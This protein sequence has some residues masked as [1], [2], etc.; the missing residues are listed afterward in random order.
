MTSILID[1]RRE[2]LDRLEPLGYT[3]C[4]HPE[5]QQSF[6]TMETLPAR[7]FLDVSFVDDTAVLF[8]SDANE[9][10]PQLVIHLV[11]AM[12]TAVGRRGLH[13]SLA[14]GKTEVL[15]NI[16][17]RGS[18]K[19]KQQMS[20]M[21]NRLQWQRDGHDLSVH[22]VANY[23][24][25]GTNVQKGHSHAQEISFRGRSAKSQFGI[26]ARCFYKKAA[27]GTAN[28][29]KI[30][31]ALSM[32]RLL[33]NAHI[34]CGVTDKEWQRWANHIRAPVALLLKGRI[35]E[36]LK[37]EFSTDTLCSA[38][39][40]LPPQ[41][42][43]H[44]ARLNYLKRLTQV[45][46]RA[47][48]TLILQEDEWTEACLQSLAWLSQHYPY[49]LPANPAD[50]FAQWLLV[51]SLDS[52]WKGRI[53]TAAKACLTFRQLQAEDLIWNKAF[54]LQFRATA[55][56]PPCPRVQQQGH[57]ICDLCTSGFTSRRALAMHA[58]KVHGYKTL[59]KYY[60]PGDVCNHCLRWFR[61]RKRLQVH[62]TT[63][64][65]CLQVLQ[66]CYP[67]M[68]DDE[69][70]RL[71]DLDAALHSQLKLAGWRPTTALEPMLQL[72]GPP[73]PPTGSEDAAIFYAKQVARF[74]PGGTAFEFLQGHN[75]A[76][77]ADEDLPRGP[78]SPSQPAFILQSA[79]GPHAASGQLG[80]TDLAYMYAQ[81][82]IRHQVFVH[83]YSGYRRTEDL[84]QVLQET[85]LHN[86]TVLMVISVDICLQRQSGDLA[87]D[88]AVKWW[89]DRIS[90]GQ[91]I[92]FGGGPPCESY[93]AARYLEG[94]PRALRTA[95]HPSGLPART[96]TEF[97]QIR[98]GTRLVQFLFELILYGAPR[99]CCSFAEHPQ[100]PIWAKDHDPVSIWSS[101]AARLLKSMQCT[102]VVSFDQ[103]IFK[104]ESRKPTTLLLVRMTGVRDLI[105]STGHA[106]RCCHGRSVHA[107][108][109]GKTD[110][111]QFC[112]ARAKIYPKG[113]NKAI[114]RG[115]V[116]HANR[117]NADGRSRDFP[118]PELD[119]LILNIFA[120]DDIVQPDCHLRI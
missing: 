25:L 78:L 59:T 58:S 12:I 115:V 69:V 56:L 62:L 46:P 54:E 11:D 89:K 100:Y 47:L 114:A 43:V 66:S 75:V 96:A 44:V 7:A 45:C 101:K 119:H 3:W 48:W 57:W 104:S 84:H 108:L 30:F 26:L 71:D 61:N 5:P 70:Q 76:P 87:R 63:Q 73:L 22:L 23:K 2:A 60:A 98:L 83:F 51:I 107:P 120:E 95:T 41:D 105:L 8:H 94:G 27:V 68:A 111:G 118:P 40:L 10:I 102:S 20:Q 106:G 36:A 35:P 18:R 85:T 67:P 79:C 77:Q 13:L 31:R 37:F 103:C 17:G 81:L 109:K 88:G 50:S 16:R 92:G 24:H 113:L 55:G 1:Y 52:G 64:V 86:G 99:G 90:A 93:T 65:G 53:K 29:V 32:S 4:G 97:A 110:Q 49:K 42:G 80:T 28:K 33:Y 91:L 6:D 19:V 9:D 39:G 116:D 21:N 15:W 34:W 14:D 117:L 38:V 112:T 82:H 72:Q 74:G